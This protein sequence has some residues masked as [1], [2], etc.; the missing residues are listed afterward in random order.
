M[1]R[2]DHETDFAGTIAVSGGEKGGDGGFRDVSGTTLDFDGKVGSERSSE[3][4]SGGDLLVDPTNVAIGGAGGLSIAALQGALATGDVAITTS[5][6][7]TDV[8]NILVL[9][10]CGPWNS[11]STLTLRADA[12]IAIIGAGSIGVMGGLLLDAAGEILATGPVGVG[13]FTL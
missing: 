12:L 8:G 4:A 1:V 9:R 11:Q 5:A 2:S 7:G 3:G 10:R 13:T 6:P